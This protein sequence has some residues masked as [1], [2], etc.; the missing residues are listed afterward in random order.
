MPRAIRTGIFL[1]LALAAMWSAF[2]AVVTIGFRTMDPT[3]RVLGRMAV[4]SATIC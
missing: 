3:V 1:W 2:Y 4:G